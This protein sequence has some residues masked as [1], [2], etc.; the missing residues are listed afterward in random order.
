M[1]TTCAVQSGL[2]WLSFGPSRTLL[3]QPALSEEGQSEKWLLL[4]GLSLLHHPQPPHTPT[5]GHP[6]PH[7]WPQRGHTCTFTL[8]QTPSFPLCPYKTCTDTHTYTQ[9]NYMGIIETWFCSG[10]D[11]TSRT[12]FVRLYY[13]QIQL[14]TRLLLDHS[15]S[16]H[17]T[18]PKIPATHHL[19]LPLVLNLIFPLTG[20][21]ILV[22][23]RF[24]ATG[25]TQTTVCPTSTQRADTRRTHSFSYQYSQSRSL[26]CADNAVIR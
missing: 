18:L 17:P 4:S 1:N 23:F 12:W 19:P 7:T 10:R 16:P 2:A 20:V 24:S 8:S 22:V 11:V 15:K 3:H 13:T 5:P 21:T 9:T 14:V 6:V 26:R 25:P